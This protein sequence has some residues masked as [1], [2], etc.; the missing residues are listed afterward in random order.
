MADKIRGITIEL[1]GDAS[2]LSKALQGVNKEIKDTQAQ[3][4]DVERLLKLDP[5]NTELLAQKQKLL[6]DQIQ[7]TSK[8]LD[9]LK[10]AQADMDKNGVDKNSEQYMALQRE[11]IST[12]NDLKT[13]QSSAE[14]VESALSSVADEAEQSATAIEK[15]GAAGEKLKTVGDGMVKTGKTLTK[16][17]TVPLVGSATLAAK[18]FADVDKTMQLANKTMGNTAEQA[19]LI[20]KAMEEAAANSTFGMSD[21]ATA[22][23][24]FARAGL[25]AE[26]AASA[27]APAMNLAAGEGGSLDTVSAG[28][29]ATINGFHGSFEDASYYADIFAAACNNSALDVNSLSSAMS[30]AA[31]IFA[32]A[33]YTV[34]DAALYM[35]VM[36]NNGIEAD[37]AAN[38]LKTGMARLIKPA[39]EGYNALSDLGL[40]TEDGEMAFLNLDGS[41]KDSSEVLK[42]L[43]DS[44][45]T[46]SESEQIAAASAIFGKNQMAPWLALINT[47][48]DDVN[49]LNKS[50][51]NSKGTTDEMAEAMMGGFGGSLERIK[52]SLDVLMTTIGQIIAEFLVPFIKKIQTLLDK[53]NGLDDSQKKNIVTI[54][55]IA[56]AIGPLLIVLGKVIGSV[57]TI[58]TNLPMIIGFISKIWTLI[59]ANPIGLLVTAIVGLVTLI[60]TKGDEIQAILG[61]LDAWLQGVF[62][63]DWTEVFGPVLGG[64]LNGF[65]NTF[66]GVWDGFK[67]ILDGVID[68][69]RGVFSADWERAWNGVVELF[70]GIIGTIVSIFKAPLNGIISLINGAVGH[71]NGLI[72]KVNK[73][74]GVN[75]GHI[76]TIPMLANGGVLSQGSAIVG[77]VGPELLTMAGNKAV[78]Q[79]LGAGASAPAAPVY[80]TVQSVL[81]GRVIAESTTKYQE[82]AARAHG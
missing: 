55:G 53:F 58:L 18:K 10:K 9:T 45:S 19:Q 72:D 33:G 2:G 49:K 14:G 65:F 8:K 71:I 44:F 75:V 52:S 27:L 59:A 3:L 4:K 73:I 7:N 47:S 77:E 15:L 50:L 70:S 43:H 46:L 40:I 5:K 63:K 26:Q 37:K 79:P 69:I 56:A 42:M 64:I 51:K 38:S 54:L 67:G 22:M 61:K 1:G 29:V 13:L 39:K 34:Q 17:V 16:T 24:N 68:I 66:K 25:N 48:T 80:I 60:A 6:G 76:G 21:A 81:D 12:E 28:L 57:G 62:T 32:A 30:V 35:G 23:L 31:P 82:R 20:N 74:P 11:I 41:L 36:A 78:V